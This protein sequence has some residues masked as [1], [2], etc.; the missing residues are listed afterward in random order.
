M[1]ISRTPLRVTLGGGGTDLPSYYEQFGGFVVAAA[2]NRYVFI[3]INKTFGDDYFL[4]YSE[5]ERAKFVEDIK[6]PI[7]RSALHL[8]PIGPAIELV[9]V[10]DI[11]AGTGL[12]SSGAFT[13]G[14]LRALYAFKREHVTAASLAEE[15]CRI[16]IEML[17]GPVGKQDQYIAAFGGLTCFEIERDGHVS[18]SPL[19]VSNDTLRDLEEHLCMFFTGYSRPAEAV[20]EEQRTKSSSGDKDMLDSLHYVMENGLATKE[21]LQAGDTTRFATLMDEHWQRKRRRSALMSNER[22]DRCYEVAMASGALGG[23]L[24]GAGSG[25]FLLFYAKDVDSVRSA[26]AA[27][28]LSEVRFGFDFDGSAPLVRD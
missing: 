25:G 26:M 7:I 19:L 12:G 5:L 18:V 28:G 1:I 16:E 13:V 21:A 27:E 2:I 20:L 9:S 15:A 6:H 4:K 8:H 3:A 10:A 14:L 24:V 11:P 17:G 23:K 22:I